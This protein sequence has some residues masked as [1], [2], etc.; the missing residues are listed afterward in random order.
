VTTNHFPFFD[1]LKTSAVIELSRG[2][3]VNEQLRGNSLNDNILIQ[4]QRVQT[5][6]NSCL[7][8]NVSPLVRHTFSSFHNLF[9]YKAHYQPLHIA[10][11]H[12]M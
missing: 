4:P 3:D 10:H 7:P 11:Y 12:N 9:W 6:A 1:Q 5:F 2:N 8:A